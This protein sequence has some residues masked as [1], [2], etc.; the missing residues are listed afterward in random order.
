[1]FQFSNCA[2]T[3]IPYGVEIPPFDFRLSLISLPR[4][5]G[6]TLD[7]I[8]S[9]TPYLR[10]PSCQWLPP[11]QPGR[12]KVGLAWAG[13]PEHHQDAARSLRLEQLAPILQVLGV[14]FYNLQQPVP[15]G[16]QACLQT[17][18]ASIHSNL[19][20]DDF[21]DTASV[22]AEMDL[23]ISVDT[24]VAHLAGALGKPVWIL[25]QHSSDWRWFLDCPDS[26]W[27]PTAQLF[28]QVERNEWR[29]PILRTAEAMKLKARQ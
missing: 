6:V 8:P 12:L 16:D 15:A 2:D 23:V 26:P 4:V 18:S 28:R 29:T 24:A 19:K 21:L 5:L 22:I 13:N 7:T 1:M 10:A 9:R 14:A 11:A 27:Y 20:L 17:M 25:L 3:V